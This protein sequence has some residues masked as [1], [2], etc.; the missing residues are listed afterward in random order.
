MQHIN[1]KYIFFGKCPFVIK[2]VLVSKSSEHRRRMDGRLLV[3]RGREGVGG[4]RAIRPA[5]ERTPKATSNLA[6]RLM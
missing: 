5:Y 6:K 3:V 2:A 1:I 4:A